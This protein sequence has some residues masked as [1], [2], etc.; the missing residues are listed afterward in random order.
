MYKKVIFINDIKQS[1]YYSLEE[2]TFTI[3]KTYTVYS[4]YPTSIHI[5][6]DNNMLKPFIFKAIL[7]GVLQKYPVFENYFEYEVK[8]KFNI[9]LND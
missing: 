6:D 8:R 2:Y 5:V 3:G 1:D 9:L 7:K 4:K